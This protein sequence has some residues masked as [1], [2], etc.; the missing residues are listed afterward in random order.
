VLFRAAP[1]ARFGRYSGAIISATTVPPPSRPG[2][3]ARVRLL[4]AGALVHAPYAGG[5]GHALLAGRYSYTGLLATLFSDVT[6]QYWDYQ[7]RVGQKVASA[8]RAEAFGF[9]A[10]DYFKGPDGDFVGSE[11]H[12]LGLRHTW[13]AAPETTLQSAVTF[14]VDRSR[15]TLGAVAN[16]TL[17]VRFEFSHPLSESA[18][19]SY[20]ASGSLE[21]FHFNVRREAANFDDL[22]QLFP[23]RTDHVAG[24]YAEAEVRSGRVRL[25]PGV[26]VDRYG[27]LD[28]TAVGVDP[29]ISAGFSVTPQVELVHGLGLLHQPPGFLPEVPGAKLAGLRGGL[30]TSLQHSFGVVASPSEQLALGVTLFQ[31]A[32]FDLNDPLGTL[33]KASADIESRDTRAQGYARG[34]EVELSRPL[35]ERLSGNVSYTLSRNERSRGAAQGVAAFDRTHLAQLGTMYRFGPGYSAGARALYYSGVPTRR[36]TDSGPRY[37]Q[38]DRAAPMLRLDLRAERRF[39]LGPDHYF[40]VHLELLNAT[41]S[42]EVVRRECGPRSC[43]E[44]VAGPFTLPNV[45]VEIGF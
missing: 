8:H 10:F 27:S 37:D 7:A 17:G 20:G 25:V 40:S 33:G 45:G 3:E 23:T 34:L 29:R 9:G 28:D 2:G 21:A 42:R 44:D 15:S 31:S 43:T 1:P 13:E 11:F 22:R 14:G 35:T 19:L 5:E 39:T 12:R 24:A 38:S 36:L 26:R 16:R 18:K 32:F 4:D 6:V 41:L 30:Q